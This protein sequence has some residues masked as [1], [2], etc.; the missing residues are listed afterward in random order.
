MKVFD[1]FENDAEGRREKIGE[2]AVVLRGF[3]K[4]LPDELLA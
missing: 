4:L 3:A 2:H 1:L